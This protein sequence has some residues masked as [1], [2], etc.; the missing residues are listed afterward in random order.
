MDARRS[1]FGFGHDGSVDSLTRFL[2]GVRVVQ[3][4]DV[5]DFIAFLLSASDSPPASV[6]RQFTS[7]EDIQAALELT[8]VDVIAKRRQRGWVYDRT[9]QL[10]QSDRQDE[11][12]TLDDLIAIGDVTF[13]IV[14]LGSGVRLGIDRDSDG[15]LDGD[16]PSPADK[17]PPIQIISSGVAFPSEGELLLQAQYATLPAPLIAFAWQKNGAPLSGATSES[18]TANEPAEYT[19]TLTTAFQAYTSAPVRITEVPLIV[20][21]S[22]ATQSVRL[23]S[24]AV[25]TTEKLGRD[26]VQYQW[27]FNG[28]S[29]GTGASLSLTNVRL[30]DE[31]EYRV[32]AA[33][34]YGV[35][36]SAPVRLGVLI[37]PVAVIK[38][39]NQRVVPG[40]QA[41]FSFSISGHP[42]PFGYFLK[43]SSN[44]LTSY[45]TDERS[46]FLML[47]NVQPSS[48]GT[49]RVVVTNAANTS[50][51]VMDPATLT[52]LTD[53]DGDGL[54]DD[55]E[56]QYATDPNGD[57]DHD[58]HSNREE[59]L[60]GTDPLDAQSALRLRIAT[61]LGPVPSPGIEFNAMS[62][63]TYT[64]QWRSSLTAQ[65]WSRLADF[66]AVPSNRVVT[67]TTALGAS[68]FYRVVT[69]RAP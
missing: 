22:P 34:M 16:D 19:V 69:P 46:G 57:P 6:G 12:A 36:T 59:Y 27:L 9:R 41:T 5:A 28:Q 20:S 39:L 68:G 11:T 4:Q 18:L 67:I 37:N 3:D 24:N 62:N 8:G 30:S 60:A 49:Y 23:G 26:P 17:H 61:P 53:S 43:K 64:I 66:V 7:R 25:F 55:W 63:K 13:T 38:P 58:G 44:I 21:I 54:P 10:F 52:V 42:P 65:S 33:N 48:A 45:V 35:V 56:A 2:N 1:G 50:G 15:I 32:V 14:P 51:L 29:V 47:S 40:D 31:G